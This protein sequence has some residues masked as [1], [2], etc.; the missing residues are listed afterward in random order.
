MLQSGVLTFLGAVLIAG[1]VGA[2]PVRGALEGLPGHGEVFGRQVGSSDVWQFTVGKGDWVWTDITADGLD[3]SV[4]A[5]FFDAL[6]RKLDPIV[7]GGCSVADYGWSGTGVGS[8]NVNVSL[9]NIANPE[10]VE[11]F[12]F[13]SEQTVYLRV[14]GACFSGCGAS[15]IAVGAPPPPALPAHG[16]GYTID[17]AAW[18]P[19]A[20]TRSN[21]TAIRATGPTFVPEPAALAL[22]GLGLGGAVLSRKRR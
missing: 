2:T 6:G 19:D 12:H 20:D 1:Q 11:L 14:S 21:L 7:A 3:F 10:D 17:L 15:S 16:Y 8:C 4:N 13:K 5:G 9:N 18:N 22:L